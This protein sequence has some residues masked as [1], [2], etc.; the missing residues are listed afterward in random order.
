MAWREVTEVS[1]LLGDPGAGR[2]AARCPLG[3]G[4]L[5]RTSLG[6][7]VAGVGAVVWGSVGLVVCALGGHP[8]GE[9][10]PCPGR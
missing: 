3:L 6:D 1:T 8:L 7:A 2:A 9:A 5:L 4:C 10:L